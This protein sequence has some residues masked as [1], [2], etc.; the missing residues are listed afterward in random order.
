VG[1][2]GLTQSLL[3]VSSPPLL[4]AKQVSSGGHENAEEPAIIRIFWVY[5]LILIANASLRAASG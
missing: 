4:A 5:G 3:A 1:F 2:T